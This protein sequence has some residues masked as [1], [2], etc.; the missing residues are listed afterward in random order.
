MPSLSDSERDEMKTFLDTVSEGFE[1]KIV[2]R[3]L[4]AELYFERLES[5]IKTITD[6]KFHSYFNVVADYSRWCKHDSDIL[7]GPSRGSAG[8]SLVAYV[9]DIT[10]VDPIKYDLIFSRFIS[11]DRQGFPDIDLDFPKSRRGEVVEYLGNKYGH[12]HI[13]GI[14]SLGTGKP[15]GLLKDL[16]RAY[17]IPLE[18]ANQMSKILG[19]VKDID[20]ARVD[21]SWEEVLDQAGD[22]LKPFIRRYPELFEKMNKMAGVI[23]QPG[24]HAAGVVVSNKP[25]LGIL[26]TRKGNSGIS[27]AFTKD[28]VEELGFVMF[29]D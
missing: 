17:G 26:P 3:G 11:E 22:D 5:E 27:S 12:D 2:Q 28:E 16:S 25:L 19:K 13:C 15:K 9:M 29:L 23:R 20:T 7:M 4:D 8:G 18:E 21:V 24:T 14:G 6:K 1:R 10:E